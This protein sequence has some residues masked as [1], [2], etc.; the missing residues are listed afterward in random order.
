[1]NLKI[2]LAIGSL[3]AKILVFMFGLRVNCL[4]TR[5]PLVWVQP[6]IRD[7]IHLALLSE[8]G[9]QISATN[10]ID[11]NQTL[12]KHILLKPN[13]KFSDLLKSVILIA[14]KDLLE[15]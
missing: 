1:M 14:E 15:L 13:K 2:K 6:T 7:C 8:H 10:S 12:K 4:L 5:Y 3:I 9:Y 11:P